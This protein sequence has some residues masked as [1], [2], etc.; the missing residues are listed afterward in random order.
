MDIGQQILFFASALGAFNGVILSVY[1]FF[2]KKKRSV[3]ITFL[4]IL[5]LSLSIRVIK[6]VFRYFNPSLPKIYLQIGLS[7][8]FLIGPSLYYFFRALQLKGQPV[9]L[10]WKLTW[11]ALAA[12]ILVTGVLV[13][14]Q[15][16][17]VTWNKIIVYVIYGQWAMYLVAAGVLLKHLLKTI[18][19]NPAALTNTDQF[20]LMLYIGNC[21]IYAI[22]VLSWMGV[23]W[24]MH[25]SGPVFFSLLLYLTIFFHLNGAKLENIGLP[26]KPEKRK[27]PAD[28][29]LLWIE[30]LEAVIHEK[31]LYQDPNLKLN[32]LAKYINI[33]P[34]QLSQLLN[35]NLGKSFSTY[36]NEY[37]IQ[38]AC[39][40][41]SAND[42]L[43]FEA[44]G[45]EVGYN[46][47]ST[48][49]TAFKKVTATT[50]ALYKESLPNSH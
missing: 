39:K 38:E 12:I 34:H 23:V 43:T 4:C 42:R 41:I 30:K 13:P 47:K 26:E 24:G 44:I 21:L 10:S 48:F 11:G 27:L 28:D 22:Y 45:Y 32:D 16:Y 31:K 37:R 6:S 33:T 14:Y 25:M 17:P 35:D 18:F 1:L 8:C 15:T 19:V 5:L 40:L 36:I 20:W 9:P 50:P 49:Y 3:A 46:S 7:A 2:Q 29:A